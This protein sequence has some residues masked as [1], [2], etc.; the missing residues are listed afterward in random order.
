M[1]QKKFDLSARIECLTRAATFIT[2]KDDQTIANLVYLT[3]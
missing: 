2:L 1:L 3:V